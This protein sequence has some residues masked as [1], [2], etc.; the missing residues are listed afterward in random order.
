MKHFQILKRSWD[1]L[2]AYKALWVFG[3]IL[4]L[5]T[6]S[7]SSGG[8]SG[9]GGG[10]GGS[11]FLLPSQAEVAQGVER[12]HAGLARLSAQAS[13]PGQM[14]PWQVALLVAGGLLAVA[15]SVLF[16]IGRFVSYTAHIRMVDLYEDDG[17]KL[18]WR[19][20]FKLGWSKAAWRTFLI[21]LLIGLAGF[22]VFGGLFVLAALPWVIGNLL[23]DAALVIGILLSVGVGIFV[24]FLAILAAL[25]VSLLLEPVGRV[26][27]LEDRGVFDSLR[28]GVRLVKAHLV[29]VGLM[30]LLTI[31]VR[32]LAGF[33]LV[34]LSLF[35]AILALLLGGGL[36]GLDHSLLDQGLNIF[37]ENPSLRT[38]RPHL[39]QINPQ[40]AGIGA[41]RGGGMKRGGRRIRFPR[42]PYGGRIGPCLIPPGGIG[43]VYARGPHPCKPSRCRHPAE[44]R[45]GA[46]APRDRHDRGRAA[47]R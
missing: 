7:A 2:W 4:A 18:T 27:V 24:L 37:P 20:G 25:L 12:L 23:G 31:G 5:T 30:W 10:G 41:N 13:Q 36:G 14:E 19:Q 9:G 47:L 33:V 15:L 16:T 44:A 35:V 1:I 3:I 8:S 21:S 40:F 39:G 38:S 22:L 28:Q 17:V 46:P 11:S 32:I 29:D 42:A 26:C 6:A 43:L 45:R 34:P